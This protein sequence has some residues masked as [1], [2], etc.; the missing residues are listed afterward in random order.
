[1]PQGIY[2]TIIIALVSLKKTVWDLSMISMDKAKTTI[3]ELSTIGENSVS[4]MTLAKSTTSTTLVDGTTG[5][6]DSGLEVYAP[7]WFVRSYSV[8]VGLFI[9]SSKPIALDDIMIFNN[10]LRPWSHR[11]LITGAVALPPLSHCIFI[12]VQLVML[13]MPLLFLSC[14]FLLRVHWIEVVL[15][16]LGC[17]W[18]VVNT[19]YLYNVKFPRICGGCDR[20]TITRRII[21]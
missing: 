14:M 18:R 4:G 17:A 21:A 1:M 2:P 13:L 9:W 7:A 6:Q 3:L 12:F 8:G 16:V 5:W 10:R 11:E 15:T 20:P 19:Y